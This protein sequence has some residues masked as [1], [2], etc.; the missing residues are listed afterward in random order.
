[1]PNI[2]SPFGQKV[3]NGVTIP[4][5]DRDGIC[6]KCGA[7]IPVGTYN[8]SYNTQ[9]VGKYSHRFC[10]APLMLNARELESC[11][12]TQ[13]K[14]QV[15][16]PTPAPPTLPI[17]NKYHSPSGFVCT[18]PPNHTGDHI[19]HGSGRVL[20]TWPQAP[21]ATQK[22]QPTVVQRPTTFEVPKIEPKP[23]PQITLT[24]RA[25]IT[26][27]IK[28]NGKHKETARV[29]RILRNRAYPFLYGNPGAGKTHL[30]K[31][32]AEDMGLDFVLISCAP[33]MLKSE[34][35][36]SRSPLN[37]EYYRTAFRNAWETCKN[38]GVILFDEAGL[39][40]GSFLNV[41]N[42]AMEQRIICFPDLETVKMHSDCFL[43]FAD[44]SALYGNDNL[45]PE[46]GDA[47]GAFRDR[48]TY[49]D[50]TYDEALEL[51]ILTN[52]MQS[53]E[54][55]SVWHEIV[56]DIRKVT[57]ASGVPIFASP[58]FAYRAAKW[59]LEQVPWSLICEEELW[60]GQTQDN[61]SLVRSFVE[62]HKTAVEKL[63]AAYRWESES[64]S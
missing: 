7:S 10:G 35:T 36:G 11:V 21:L 32:L 64:Q 43:C 12:A 1:M 61:I 34:I 60:R 62:K 33:D 18:L 55:A 6:S 24:R 23:A 29:Q 19:A 30:I 14:P 8:W 38:G 4:V 28:L 17:C 41:L 26:D 5:F 48:L 59:I 25:D 42:S 47:G 39:A 37:G 45:Y 44:N 56:L 22:S 53:L 63:S 40:P 27:K 46:R 31:S 54:N 15:P 3:I 9:A 2:K 16:T 58:R 49:V 52:I 50:F 20:Q 57:Q 13:A 51:M